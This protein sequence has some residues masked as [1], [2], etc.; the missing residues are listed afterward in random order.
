[1]ALPNG[2]AYYVPITVNSSF[3]FESSSNYP[4]QIDMSAKIAADTVF[5]G[6][7]NTASNVAVYDPDNSTV[8]PRIVNLDLSNNKLLVSFDG[9]ITTSANKIYWVCVGAGVNELDSPLAFSNSNYFAHWGFDEFVNGSTT[10]EDVGGYNGTVTAPITLG[11]VGIFGNS[12]HNTGATGGASIYAT[13]TIPLADMSIEFMARMIT[14]GENSLGRFFQSGA[15]VC[16]MSTTNLRFTI[17]AVTN[18]NTPFSLN[19]WYHILITKRVTGSTSPTILYRNGIQVAS[20]TLSQSLAGG[21]IYFMNN[22]VSRASNGDLDNFGFTTDIKTLNYSKNR[23]TMFFSPASFWT[24]GTGVG[25]NKSIKVSGDW[26]TITD[27]YVKVNDNWSTVSNTY[28]VT[29]A[30]WEEIT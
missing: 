27:T 9:S 29:N 8:L 16:H 14:T 21:S 13:P 1:M 5:K 12:A 11:N 19:T 25:I 15:F 2:T 24:V 26:R 7:I 20:V 4:Y 10:K 23:Y 22:G 30:G 6:H 3:V 28:V 18:L 17:D